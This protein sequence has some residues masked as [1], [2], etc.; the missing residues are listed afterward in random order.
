MQILHLTHAFQAQ[1]GRH[2][3]YKLRLF[4]FFLRVVFRQHIGDVSQHSSRHFG[5]ISWEFLHLRFALISYAKL[6]NFKIMAFNR[7]IY[8]NYNIIN[9][10][11][12]TLV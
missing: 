4:T 6:T 10:F 2:F 9:Y 7:K 8:L 11:Y 3:V 5:L 1:K 12:L